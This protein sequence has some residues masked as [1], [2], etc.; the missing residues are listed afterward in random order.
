L[1]PR[2]LKALT[3]LTV[4]DIGPGIADNLRWSTGEDAPCSV[5][6]AKRKGDL[7][8]GVSR[9]R[10]RTKGRWAHTRNRVAAHATWGADFR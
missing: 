2:L 10:K 6:Q 3:S 8:C 5:L 9:R 1:E 4:I 7:K